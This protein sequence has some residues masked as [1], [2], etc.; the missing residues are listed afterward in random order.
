MF[1]NNSSSSSIDLD[2]ISVNEL[3]VLFTQ[4]TETN[5]LKIAGNSIEDVIKR[6][7]RREK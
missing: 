6:I 4:D 3:I 5:D 2:V 1:D 7:Y